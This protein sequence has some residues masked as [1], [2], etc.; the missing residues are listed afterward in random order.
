MLGLAL[1]DD[2]LRIGHTLLDGHQWSSVVIRGHQGSSGHTL[3]D[4]RCESLVFTLA[5]LLRLDHHLP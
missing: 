3:L 1:E 5:F 4:G 2:L